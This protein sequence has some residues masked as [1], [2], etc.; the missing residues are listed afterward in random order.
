MS[1]VLLR[2]WERHGVVRP[3]KKA[4]CSWYVKH[5]K[6][7]HTIAQK[8]DGYITR[9]SSQEEKKIVSCVILKFLLEFVWEHLV[10]KLQTLLNIFTENSHF[11]LIVI[12]KRSNHLYSPWN[13]NGFSLYGWD[14]KFGEWIQELWWEQHRACATLKLDPTNTWHWR[15]D[16]ARH[17]HKS[18]KRNQQVA[19]P[20]MQALESREIIYFSIFIFF[21]FW[22][23]LTLTK[24]E[25][26]SRF[27]KLRKQ[28]TLPIYGSPLILATVTYT[29]RSYLP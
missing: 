28:K 6:W 10:E 22:S 3:W 8:M 2:T 7:L 27:S 29:H 11:L 13:T 16:C 21:P 26:I 24:I 25:R 15:W 20:F 19:C 9:L 1:E 23:H 14:E 4:F 18:L 17:A 12:K 5:V